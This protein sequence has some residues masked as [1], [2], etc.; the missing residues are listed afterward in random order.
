MASR[1]SAA[2]AR[3][4]SSRAILSSE[5][6]LGDDPL[7]GRG[8][9]AQDP[10]RGL[11]TD[12]GNVDI[13]L[14]LRGTG[15][16]LTGLFGA[17][18]TG[19]AVKATGSIAFSGQP[20]ANATITLNGVTWTFVSGSPTGNQTQIGVSLDATLTALATDLNASA[21]VEIAKCTYTADTANDQLD[22]E[23]DIA[24]ATGNAW[25]L[26]AS[27]A[28][29][30]TV[31][32]AKLTGGG[33]RHVWESGSDGIPSFTFE[34]GHPKLVT[35]VF[36]RQPASVLESLDF[37]MGLE[38]PANGTGGSWWR[39][40]RPATRRR[41]TT[42]PT[43]TRCKRFSQGRGT[44]KQGGAAARRRHR[45]QPHLLEQRWSGCGRSAPTAR[46]TPPTRPSPPATAR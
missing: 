30:G 19:A 16:W 8:R 11:I 43:A 42:R 35:P 45:R 4:T 14:D 41:S 40:A 46:S 7:L 31:S 13:P 25:T 28:S 37:E 29:N 44:I 12:E 18:V 1:R 24:G 38:G 2:T 17:P 34:I 21:D 27:A 32:A 39:R 23:F 20:A 5:Q 10:Y 33:Y 6:P 22:I 3:S 15:L 36:F 9:N 26:A